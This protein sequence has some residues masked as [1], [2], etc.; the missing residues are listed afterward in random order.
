M[1]RKVGHRG[2]TLAVIL[3]VCGA[4]GGRGGQSG[5]DAPLQPP[6]L[7]RVLVL[8][9]GS[10]TGPAVLPREAESAASSAA[11]GSAVVTAEQGQLGACDQAAEAE[12]QDEEEGDWPHE[13]TS[14]DDWSTGQWIDAIWRQFTTPEQINRFIPDDSSDESVPLPCP[15][16]SKAAARASPGALGSVVPPPLQGVDMDDY[17][18]I[19][20]R[21]DPFAGVDHDKLYQ[22]VVK[23][24]LSSDSDPYE[25]TSDNTNDKDRSAYASG[26]CSR[27]RAGECLKKLIQE[28]KGVEEKIEQLHH[29]DPE[30][31]GVVCRREEWNATKYLNISQEQD[32]ANRALWDA[33]MGNDVQTC[34]QVLREGAQ[35]D[36]ANWVG[37][38]FLR[39]HPLA[40]V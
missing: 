12:F 9:G 21:Q 26:G 5:A 24:D 17:E 32:A 34:R 22:E 18:A 37:A 23:Y 16:D 1:R 20:C 33:C 30:L 39:H 3:A 35:V 27:E 28:V 8:R 14:T 4:A 13:P 6:L 38:V 2:L 7:L 36:S 15:R 31:M 40:L 11:R 10:P 19:P 25:D 29:D